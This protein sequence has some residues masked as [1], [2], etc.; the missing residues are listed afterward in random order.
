M[1]KVKKIKVK[2]RVKVKMK[3]NVMMKRMKRGNGGLGQ[4]LRVR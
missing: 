2:I 3:G 4:K 1:M